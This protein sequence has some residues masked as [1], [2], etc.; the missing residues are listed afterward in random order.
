MAALESF[1]RDFME[2]KFA[3]LALLTL[4][5]AWLSCKFLYLDAFMSP[6]RNLPGPPTSMFLGNMLEL[7]G[8][9]VLKQLQSGRKNMEGFL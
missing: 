2:W 9:T 4:I 7:N 5:I 3:L 1:V 8:R 6:L